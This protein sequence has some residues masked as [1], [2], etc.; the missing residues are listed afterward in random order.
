M[1]R[2]SIEKFGILEPVVQGRIPVEMWPEEIV[3]DAGTF[4]AVQGNIANAKSQ[5]PRRMAESQYN[6]ISPELRDYIPIET[7]PVSM[8][9]TAQGE[10]TQQA[11]PMTPTINFG[12]PTQTAQ[13]Q[14][15]SAAPMT[16][17]ISAP[18]QT[19]TAGGGLSSAPKPIAPAYTEATT[20]GL[21]KTT[22]AVT[23]A[24]TPAG[25]NTST[26]RITKAQWDALPDFMRASI[27]T[28]MWPAEAGTPSS[29]PTTTYA[30][31]TQA[32]AQ[33]TAQMSTAQ[34][35]A[36]PDMV[37]QT[38]PASQRPAAAGGYN[39][40]LE[41]KPTP[42][43]A[44]SGNLTGMSNFYLTSTTDKNTKVISNPAVT[45]SYTTPPGTTPGTVDYDQAHPTGTGQPSTP[46]YDANG[47][48]LSVDPSNGLLYS[49]APITG[50]STPAQVPTIT[51]ATKVFDAPTVETRKEVLNPTIRLNT[52]ETVTVGS[53]GQPA[54]G[55]NTAQAPIT[56]TIWTANTN[57]G[58]SGTGSG[59]QTT[60]GG[61]TVSNDQ[62][63]GKTPT[64][65][66]KEYQR[67]PVT[68]PT[69]TTPT[70]VSGTTNQNTYKL[71][72][73]LPTATITPKNQ[74]DTNQTYNTASNYQAQSENPQASKLM[75][76]VGKNTQGLGKAASSST[77]W[78]QNTQQPIASY[79]A[80]GNIN[81]VGNVQA[82]A[83]T[84]SGVAA[85]PYTNTQ[86]TNQGQYNQAY[87]EAAPQYQTAFNQNKTP[88]MGAVTG[89]GTGQYAQQNLNMTGTGLQAWAPN[90]NYNDINKI[91]DL[92][93]QQATDQAT[94]ER[95][96]M[97]EDLAAKY[98]GQGL[99][100]GAASGATRTADVAMRTALM[101]KLGTYDLAAAQATEQ[102]AAEERARQYERE[103]TLGGY[104]VQNQQQQMANA[105]ARD[106]R[107]GTQSFTAA[108]QDLANRVAQG[109][110]LGAQEQQTLQ[111][112][113]DRTFQQTQ[114]LGTA[115]NEATKADI[116]NAFARQ[117]REGAQVFSFAA[118]E[119]ARKFQ[120]GQ[121]ITDA[122]LK[123]IQDEMGNQF[124]QQER[125]GT[126]LYGAE[127]DQ[128]AKQFE[129]QQTLTAQ[130]FA[131]QKDQLDRQFQQGQM[132]QEQYYNAA[133]QLSQQAS[134]M[135]QT[136]Q[137]AEIDTQMAALQQQ[138]ALDTLGYQTL[139]NERMA[140]IKNAADL[141]SQAFGF[142]ADA[143]L[144]QLN[145]EADLG[146][147]DYQ[148][149]IDQ[150]NASYKLHLDSLFARGQ[151]GE[152]V[153]INNM[154]PD[155]Q[156][157]VMAGA[158]GMAIE[159]Y[160]NQR[161]DAV[162]R[163]NAL[164][165]ALSSALDKKDIDVE[166]TM[167]AF[168]NMLT[169]VD[170][171]TAGGKVGT[172]TQDGM[173]LTDLQNPA[174]ASTANTLVYTKPTTLANGTTLPQGTYKVQR[175]TKTETVSGGSLGV[176][177]QDQIEYT[178]AIDTS[179]KRYVVGKE[180]TKKG[181]AAKNDWWNNPGNIL[182]ENFWKAWT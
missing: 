93:K 119:A 2:I 97:L 8:V 14:V 75:A 129:Q 41:Q 150:S 67:T 170:N 40:P 171:A 158:S 50:V 102:R 101:Q 134:A 147:I 17:T 95:N 82:Y 107:L 139:S 163:R 16:P 23:P 141:G 96:K 114:R 116:A 127:Q 83:G 145:N 32:V 62:Y 105:F 63:F 85:N 26:T 65:V 140:A 51:Y 87:T 162:A 90:T 68:R 3:S 166:K 48:R 19:A 58:A 56:P 148:N 39:S 76:G 155:E 115:E 5:P 137:K 6:S 98:A 144:A 73:N 182:S 132:T 66:V 175:E 24:P 59:S 168:N 20:T 154:T 151:S 27:P 55:A 7:L 179:G 88:T 35:D 126:Q 60:G 136:S 72:T 47:N 160:K 1:A 133:S 91:Y 113:L 178:Y 9:R 173:S 106:E 79:S 81:K 15:T 31:P 61:T 108:E 84:Q 52:G 18:V 10:I 159:M 42:D 71:P 53:I 172:G 103:N 152:N 169:Q 104:D 86:K 22:P 125:L 80:Q 21:A 38:I 92:Q 30:A 77:P 124:T 117:E 130:D 57:T 176:E 143:A 37:K 122:E 89:P 161:E 11:A 153:N 128:Y 12:A 45:G 167:I 135:A 69:T 13:G 118:D 123:M 25:T 120:S 181:D 174:A 34:W 43:I 109:A 33:L 177:S 78:T 28:S 131:A 44:N 156:A 64:Q 94:T 46:Y 29:G 180:T 36:L 164:T 99:Q 111:N 138:Y 110:Q 49:N 121:A 112:A 149:A 100:G 165:L 54:T 70:L 157:A 146:K 142:Q 4:Q 74:Y